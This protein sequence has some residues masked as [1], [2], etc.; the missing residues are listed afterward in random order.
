MV[1]GMQGRGRSSGWIGSRSTRSDRLRRAGPGIEWLISVPVCIDPPR[2][3]ALRIARGTYETAARRA[4]R[5]SRRT[6]GSSPKSDE[7]FQLW[8]RRH[9]EYHSQ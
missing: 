4:W 5:P 2:T 3:V 7:G 9:D 8:I 1:S 6:D